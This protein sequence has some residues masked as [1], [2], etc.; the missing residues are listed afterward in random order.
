MI[1]AY[2]HLYGDDPKAMA[3]M[4]LV[5][6]YFQLEKVSFWQDDYGPP[7]TERG[8][9]P[10]D[11]G[12]WLMGART[13]ENAA[14]QL[15]E[16]TWRY[17]PELGLERTWGRA[18][19]D[20]PVGAGKV[21]LG[22]VGAFFSGAVVLAPEPTG[23]TKAG[24][25][26]GVVYSVDFMGEGATQ[27]FGVGEAGGMSL[28]DAGFGAYGEYM[29]GQEGRDSA[30]FWLNVSRFAET[31]AG[32]LNVTKFGKVK[33]R[34]S[35]SVWNDLSTAAK[36]DYRAGSQALQY[37]YRRFLSRNAPTRARA[38]FTDADPA[39]RVMGSARLNHADEIAEMRRLMDAEGVEIIER[40]GTMAYCP[41]SRAGRP[42]QFIIDP[43]A[44]Y[45]A[46]KHE[47]RHFLDD[48]ASGWD[49]MSAL[50]DKNTRWAWESA[51]YAEEI[52]L[53]RRLGRQDVID[54][55]IKLRTKQWQN[56]FMPHLGK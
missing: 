3:A 36:L 27:I 33:L 52:S 8:T 20:V 53:M 5:L 13:N 39:R 9:I 1:Q 54:E 14:E 37:A 28:L 47:F 56:I 46:W 7:D 12:N 11:D 18:A 43:D 2:E 40:S 24:G 30:L 51:A 10:I 6:S 48:Q 22:G 17:F 19:W 45:S 4:F 41:S 34:L 38:F 31:G 15:Y 29:N 23:L 32:L 26:I 49:G 16:L 25:A 35:P 21:V 50:M 42:G 55:L 44:S